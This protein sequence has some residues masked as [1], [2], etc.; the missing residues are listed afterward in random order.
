V[1]RLYDVF[2]TIEQIFLVMEYLEGGDL[3]DFLKQKDFTTTNA[4]KVQIMSGIS[5]GVAYLHSLG[6]IH[7]DLKLE[8][9]MMSSKHDT[10]MPKLV[11]FG[12]SIILGEG[13]T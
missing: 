9:V 6:I 11:D 12:L 1:I 8:N 4:L 10:A 5:E 7:R 2:E 13:Q 3:F